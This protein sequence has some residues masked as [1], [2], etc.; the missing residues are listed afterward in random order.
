MKNVDVWNS[1]QE[2]GKQNKKQK[3]NREN[4]RSKKELGIENQNSKEGN[5]EIE[6]EK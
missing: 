3:R 6:Q 4:K 1:Q 5:N 2:Y